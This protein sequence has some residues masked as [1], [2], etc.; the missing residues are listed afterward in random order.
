MLRASTKSGGNST[1]SV[2]Q[3]RPRM[4]V[5]LRQS[6][7]MEKSSNRSAELDALQHRY[8][9][10]VCQHMRTI[11]AAVRDRHTALVRTAKAQAA[12]RHITI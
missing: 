1:R 5:L 11:R 10:H 9:D 6:T 7:S 2:S 8:K 4:G 3:P 12:V